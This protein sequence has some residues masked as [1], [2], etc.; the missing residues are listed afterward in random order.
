MDRVARLQKE[1]AQH[2]DSQP[3]GRGKAEREAYSN[4]TFKVATMQYGF[5]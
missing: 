3:D 2:N 1:Y 4:C 5:V